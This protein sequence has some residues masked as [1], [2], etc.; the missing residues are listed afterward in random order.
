MQL[1]LYHPRYGYYASGIE[2]TGWSGDFVTAPELDPAF[3]RL[4][5]RA[6]EGVWEACGRPRSFEVAEIGPGEG[7]FAEA[8]LSSVAGDF[9]AALSYRLVERLPALAARQR[10]RLEG[11]E[12]AAWTPAITDIPDIG[13]GCIFANEVLDNLPVH[14][15]QQRNGSLAEV[16]VDVDGEDFVPAFLP[17]S[18]PELGAFLERVGVELAEGHVYEVPLAAQSLVARAARCL[19]RGA[20]IVVDYGHDA[21]TLAERAAGT[22]LAYSS[23][24]TDD[25]VL[26]RPGE[27]DITAHVN[28]SAI[29]G[30]CEAGGLEVHGPRSQRDVLRAL[31]LD[32]LHDGLRAE[33]RKAVDL[34]RGKDA[35]A[36]LSRRQALGA[37]ADPGGLGAL[38]VMVAVAK[39][40]PPDFIA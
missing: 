37:L 23:Q 6:F 40:P 16:C 12:R 35:V 27:K 9:A 31:G 5:A 18:S 2:R 8:V 38:E 21:H 32:D 11:F 26:E 30:A 24:G 14:L 1:A 7:G 15:V 22:L 19:G 4:W 13:A 39:I 36:A 29:R 25:G 17:P 28:W 20:L 10:E 3:G 33:H 34:G